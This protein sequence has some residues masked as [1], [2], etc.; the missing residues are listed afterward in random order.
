MKFKGIHPATGE[1]L[2]GCPKHVSLTGEGGKWVIEWFDPKGFGQV[3]G[4]TSPTTEE[5]FWI[6]A[7]ISEVHAMQTKLYAWRIKVDDIFF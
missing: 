2:W 5:L 6:L 3:E 1:I 4:E 7:N